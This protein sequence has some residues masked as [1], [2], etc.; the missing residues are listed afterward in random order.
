MPALPAGLSGLNGLLEGQLAHSPPLSFLGPTLLQPRALQGDVVAISPYSSHLDPRLYAHQPAVFDPKREGMRLGGSTA[1]H[2]AVVGV[3]GVPG[4][5]FGGGK[6]RWAGA[7][8]R[9]GPP[10]CLWLS[11][12]GRMAQRQQAHLPLMICAGGNRLLCS[13]GSVGTATQELQAEIRATL[14]RPPACRCPGRHFAESELCLVTSLLLL[15]FEWQLLPREG[16][17]APGSS[18]AGALSAAPPGD[19]SGL[20]PPPDLRKLVGIKVPAGP[21]WVQCSRR[22]L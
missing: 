22:S 5:S 13:H 14:F 6:Y 11:Q 3:G 10:S 2:A 7:Q 19:P 1:P 16:A 4:L 18:A 12:G 9:P 8:V 20:L 17:P 21:C 15:L